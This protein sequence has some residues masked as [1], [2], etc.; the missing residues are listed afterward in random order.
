LCVGQAIVVRGLS[1]RPKVGQAVEGACFHKIIH[2]RKEQNVV[3]QTFVVCFPGRWAEGPPV[4]RQAIVFR[5]LSIESRA[6]L[7]PGVLIL[8]TVLVW[9]EARHEYR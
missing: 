6:S 5:R 2:A 4:V 8:S 7:A 1:S 9:R 3:S